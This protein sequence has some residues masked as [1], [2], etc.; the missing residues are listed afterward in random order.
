MGCSFPC[1]YVAVLFYSR[2]SFW[3]RSQPPILRGSIK[4]KSGGAPLSTV[5]RVR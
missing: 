1:T 2:F 5:A 4:K 3:E